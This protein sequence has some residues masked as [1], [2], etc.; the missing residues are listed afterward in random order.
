ML[1]AD[2]LGRGMHMEFQHPGYNRAIVT[3]RIV[4]LR[5]VQ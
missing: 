5:Q 3:S 2:F 4:E 1:K